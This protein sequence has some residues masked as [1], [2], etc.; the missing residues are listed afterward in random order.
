MGKKEIRSLLCKGS[1][2]RCS[3]AFFMTNTGYYRDISFESGHGF[4][5][6]S[7]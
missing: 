3:Y 1:G 4:T 5:P 7:P 2:N 6:F